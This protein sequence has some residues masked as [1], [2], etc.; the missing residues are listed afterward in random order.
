MY[1]DLIAVPH[2]MTMP[3]TNKGITDKIANNLV[4]I[5]IT[6][7]V[8]RGLAI[9]NVVVGK[10]MKYCSVDVSRKALN[11]LVHKH[12]VN[13]SKHRKGVPAIATMME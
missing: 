13:V 5:K 8:Q 3:M 4:P 10:S 7:F 9:V 2:E 11:E 6:K 1:T 12:Q